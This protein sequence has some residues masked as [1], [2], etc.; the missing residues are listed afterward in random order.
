[1]FNIQKEVLSSTGN[2]TNTY[3]QYLEFFK[4]VKSGELYINS[5]YSWT[6]LLLHMG[7]IIG[8]EIQ[9]FDT[10]VQSFQQGYQQSA[11]VGR[12]DEFV[13]AICSLR[14]E[15][16]DT[17]WKCRMQWG[18]TLLDDVMPNKMHLVCTSNAFYRKPFVEWKKKIMAYKPE[19]EKKKRCIITNCSADKPY[20]SQV[21]LNIKAAFPEHELLIVTGVLG[22]IPEGLMA[23]AP[24]YDSGLPNFWR[25]RE[26]CREYFS[27]NNHYEEVII[28]TEF[29]QFALNEVLYSCLR[30]SVIHNLFPYMPYK[31]YIIDEKTDFKQI[32]AKYEEILCLQNFKRDDDEEK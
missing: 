31:D 6:P 13:E 2:Y 15:L 5:P 29:N 10:D 7:A 28:A 32:W 3:N 17:L 24:L 25:L 12:A 20:P 18:K 1:M 11:A 9:H 22:I 23:D 8:S 19:G 26:W 30:R 4:A 14:P 27:I 21:H 16:S